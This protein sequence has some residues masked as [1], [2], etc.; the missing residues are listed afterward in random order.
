MLIFILIMELAS[1]CLVIS[2][3]CPGSHDKLD[4]FPQYTPDKVIKLIQL[5]KSMWNN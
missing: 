3:M 1:V 5:I 4:T 2:P